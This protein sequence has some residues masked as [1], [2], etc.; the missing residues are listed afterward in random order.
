M[1]NREYQRMT[2]LQYRNKALTRR[3]EA[4][5]SGAVFTSMREDYRKMLNSEEAVIR[6][7]KQDFESAHAETRK[8]RKI[9]EQATDDLTEE[10]NKKLAKKDREIS[11]M[12]KRIY[13]LMDELRRALYEAQ[14]EIED[15]K[16]QNSVLHA[17]INRDYENSSKPSV[18][19]RN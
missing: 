13:E 11:R 2:D 5:E 6:K 4:F 19:C 9:W 15:L 12:Q 7:L 1:T 8:V 18:W 3:V 10:Y 16:G 17:Q 14:T